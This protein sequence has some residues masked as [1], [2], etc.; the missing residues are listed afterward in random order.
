MLGLRDAVV[1]ISAPTMVVIVGLALDIAPIAPVVIALGAINLGVLIWFLRE[2]V[3][4]ELNQR[5]APPPP[6]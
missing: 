6:G 2:P 4:R 5:E 1:G 3:F